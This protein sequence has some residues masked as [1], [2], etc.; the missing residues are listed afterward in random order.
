MKHSMSTRLLSLLLTIALVFG[1][2][3]FALAAEVGEADETALIT[4]QTEAPTEAETVPE[5][6][7]A[8]Q[9]AEEPAEEETEAAQEPQTEETTEVTEAADET[10]AAIETVA[11]EETQAA[12]TE[13]TE[14]AAM[15]YGLNGLPEGYVLSAKELTDKQN[16]ADHDVCATTES[17]TPGVDYEEDVIL[18]AADT[19]EQALTYAAAFNAE[20]VDWGYGV[21]KLRLNGITVPQAVAASADKRLLLPA[22]YPNHIVH[23]DPVEIEPAGRG[24]DRVSASSVPQVMDWDSWVNE[25][26]DDPDPFIQNPSDFNYQYMHDTVDSYAAWGVTTGNA[27]VTVAVVDSGVYGEHPDLA[28]KVTDID[29]GIG[30]D[31]GNGHGTH[32]AG[33]I[34]ATM[35]NGVCGAGIAPNVSILNVRVLDEYGYGD[36]FGVVAGINA[37]VENG[38]DVINM[39]LGSYSYNGLEADAVKKAIDNNICVVAA[40][41]NDGSNTLCYPAGYPGVIAVGCS[42]PSNNRAFFSNYG[43]WLDV[44]APGYMILSTSNDGTYEYM[45]GTSQAT[46]VVSGVV[47]LYKSYNWGTPAQIEARLKST[48]TKAGSNLG[49]GIVNAAKMLSAKP[50]VPGFWIENSEEEIVFD[51]DGTVSGQIPCESTLQ[52]YQWNGDQNYYILYTLDGS[53]PAVK[54]GT[55]VK[56]IEYDWEPID[57]SAYAGKTITVK[58]IQVTGMGMAS[59]MLTK[60]IKVNNTDL[61]TGVT[62]SGPTRLLAGKT[63]QFTAAVEPVGKASQTV[64]WAIIDSSDNMAKAKISTKGVLTTPS[65]AA[66]ETGTVTIQAA[67]KDYPDVKSEPV[68]VTVE[69]LMPVSQMVMSTAK[70]TLFI[71][72][73]EQLSVRAFDAKK[74]ELFPEY[75]WVSSNSKVAA[76]SSD[77]EVT[78]IAKG[79]A[80]ITCKALD[81]SGK[82]AKCTV[83]VA[84][85]VESI[86]ITGQTSIAP[87]A[88]ATYKA[89]VLPATA[90]NKKVTWFLTDAPAGVTI[91]TSGK[92]TVPKGTAIDETFTVWA[93]SQ[94]G[95]AEASYTVCVAPKCTSVFVW[96]DVWPGLAPGPNAWNIDTQKLTSVGLFN[97]DLKDTEDAENEIMLVASPYGTNG[98]PVGN[99]DCIVW[100]SSNPAVASVND[101]GN[102]TAHKAGTAKITAAAM[103]GS[104]KKATV[105]IKVTVPVSTMAL[106]SSAV[107]GANG[108]S[109]L[110]AGKSVSHKVVFGDTYGKPTNQKVFWDWDV[111]YSVQ[112]DDTYEWISLHDEFAKLVSCSGGRLSVKSSAANLIRAYEAQGIELEADIVALAMDGTYASAF[113][114]YRLVT[115]TTVLKPM[116]TTVTAPAWDGTEENRD[117]YGADFYCDQAVHRDTYYDEEGNEKEYFVGDFIVTSSN[118][119]V[120]SVYGVESYGDNW[121]TVLFFPNSK[122]TAKLTIKT[123]DG[124]NKSCTI[125]VKVL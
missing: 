39:S 117:L 104:G 107:K 94:D 56:G 47:A 2:C 77:G 74:N 78:A 103:D 106:S 88:S 43:T 116:Y 72:E 18:V 12:E 122:G 85:P 61:V 89:A 113:Q 84:Q 82:S 99:D 3:P 7:A 1:C 54:N 34:A 29:I 81:G 11:A 93:A 16:L 98:A 6:E 115:P 75:S 46:P 20:L 57:L 109:L 87:G 123:T 114:G 67:S 111:G 22:A 92:V 95:H 63:A 17:L 45:S 60:K 58:A 24:N 76:V 53:I 80:T 119:K 32:V 38:A 37:A 64:T 108:M 30:T 105:T 83:T 125:T 65:L 19:E 51:S 71:D 8:E 23:L 55:V 31:D 48:A 25:V 90:Y 9:P 10:E 91:S 66:G 36:T 14:P 42:D 49:A 69:R 50:A 68:T 62:V 70:V 112:V 28:G 120:V 26:M 21:A 5:T 15:P 73:T 44:S 124:T 86:T 52:F 97:V 40:M 121:N 59:A 33:I 100:S 101:E 118:P 35:G 41:G 79:S 96:F 27:G 13:E 4:E 110:A 102:V